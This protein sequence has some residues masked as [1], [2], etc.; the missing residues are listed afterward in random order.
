MYHIIIAQIDSKIQED[1]QT[2]EVEKGQKFQVK[3]EVDHGVLIEVITENG[4][5]AQR[6]EEKKSPAVVLAEDLTVLEVL[7]A[8]PKHQKIVKKCIIVY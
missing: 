5:E 4:P 2:Q 6:E 3:A 8:D 7:E 1:L